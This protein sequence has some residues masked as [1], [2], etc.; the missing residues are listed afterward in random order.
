MAVKKKETTIEVPPLQREM[1]DFYL[2]GVTPLI[3][4][5]VAEKA[6]RELLLPMGKKTAADKKNT[7]K[8]DPIA[9][10]RASVTRLTD[11]DAPTLLGFPTSGFKKTIGTAALDIPGATKAQIGRLIRAHGYTTPIYGL[12]RVFTT[13]VRNS[14][15]N[16]TPDVRTRAI[17][18][19]WACKLSI[20]WVKPL[21][22]G[23]T[24]ANLLSAGGEIVGIGDGRQEKGA[25][26]FGLF[27][28][29]GPS[30]PELKQIMK[31]GGRKQQI[32]AMDD[33]AY[34]D[35]ETAELLTWYE[36]EITRRGR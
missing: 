11:E 36:Q 10:Y 6:K 19:N 21:L 23:T 4:N 26:D 25:Y 20:S 16:R 35:E 12:P 18:P 22:T 28:V 33:P 1:V 8:H 17:V 34:Y 27:R 5:R 13:I 2:V 3:L 30:D 9:E 7:L 29:A 32:A 15:I 24:V 14:D 31:T